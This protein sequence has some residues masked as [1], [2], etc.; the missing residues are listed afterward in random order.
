MVVAIAVFP[1][2]RIISKSPCVISAFP[3]RVAW[4]G[5]GA[6][7]DVAPQRTEVSGKI[8]HGCEDAGARVEPEHDDGGYSMPK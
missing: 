5:W 3:R 8:N 7:R 2:S 1:S 6:R 4:R